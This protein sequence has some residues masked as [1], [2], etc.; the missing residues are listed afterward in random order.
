MASA[1]LVPAGMLD[2]ATST[3][4]ACCES[5]ACFWTL[6]VYMITRNAAMPAKT[7]AIAMLRTLYVM[8]LPHSFGT[9]EDVRPSWGAI[10][11][12]GAGLECSR[13]Y[14]PRERPAVA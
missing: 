3:V 9:D 6:P 12:G 13:R 14:P 10:G 5:L 4:V 11:R 7:S 1:T 2:V 8:R